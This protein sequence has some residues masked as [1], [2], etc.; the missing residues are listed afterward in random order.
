MKAKGQGLIY[1]RG[2]IWWVQYYVRGQRFRET[3]GSSNRSDAVRLLKQRHA[4]AQSGKPLGP[5]PER[6]TF[7]DLAG[8]LLDNYRANGRRSLD[9]AEDAVNHLRGFFG[10]DARTVNITADRITLVA[11]DRP[12]F[13]LRVTTIGLS[14]WLLS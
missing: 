14:S 6:T 1:R 11:L 2:A 5:Q 13:E 9:R 7:E 3:S 4:D 10:P 8:M 12:C